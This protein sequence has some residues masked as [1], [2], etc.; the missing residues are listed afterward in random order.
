M[1]VYS[2]QLYT[3]TVVFGSLHHRLTTQVHKVEGRSTPVECCS[4]IRLKVDIV[5]VRWE[6]AIDLNPENIAKTKS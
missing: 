1:P 2:T 6:A 3:L 4:C 5:E